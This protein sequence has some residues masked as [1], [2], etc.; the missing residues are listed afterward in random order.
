MHGLLSATYKRPFKFTFMLTRVQ[1]QCTASTALYTIRHTTITPIPNI[2]T[3]SICAV[4]LRS[5]IKY[6]YSGGAYQAACQKCA[7][8]YD[9][10]TFPP[11][12]VHNMKP[13]C[14]PSMPYSTVA[15]QQYITTEVYHFGIYPSFGLHKLYISHSYSLRSVCEIPI[16]IIPVAAVNA[17]E[18]KCE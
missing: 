5:L 6:R 3:I 16:I 14:K 18:I 17:K 11:R 12:L 15:A 2:V 4:C 13:E 9:A 8:T 7:C 1:L 10:H